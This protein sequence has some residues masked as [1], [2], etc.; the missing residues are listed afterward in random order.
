MKRLRRILYAL[1]GVVI[2]AALIIAAWVGMWM[3]TSL[4]QT[5]GSIGVAGIRSPVEIVRDEDGIVTIRAQNDVDAAFALGYVH[6]QDRLVQM[7]FN[8]RLGAGRLAEVIG[9]S[10][11]PIDKLMRLLGLYR[12]RRGKD[13][14]LGAFH[15]DLLKNGS[16]PLS[17]VEWLVLDD[18][19][20]LE[21][22]LGRG[23]A[24]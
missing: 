20:T 14:R 12:D 10:A 3:P 1:F 2:L 22:A 6:A 11:L 23:G 18:P 24:R 16:L 17:I 5:A 8:R 15:D 4:P 21:Q 7:E 13:F 9:A 19:G